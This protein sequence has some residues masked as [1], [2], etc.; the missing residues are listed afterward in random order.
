MR[1]FLKISICIL[2]LGLSGCIPLPKNVDVNVTWQEKPAV[3]ELTASTPIYGLDIL[4]LAKHDANMISQELDSNSVIG[5]LMGTF[6]DIRPNLSILI[7]T[8][9][10]IAVRLH[11]IDGTTNNHGCFGS[12][13]DPN[14]LI[15]KLKIA[16]AF[17]DQYPQVKWYF[18]PVLEHGCTQSSIVQT[19]YNLTR[20]YFPQATPVCSSNGVGVCIAGML[21]ENHGGGSG[22]IVSGDGISTFD[23]DSIAY[24]SAGSVLVLSWHNCCNGRLTSEKPGGPVPPPT[25]R[26]NWCQQ[27]EIRH[28]VRILRAPAPKP[29]VAGCRD[30]LPPD[31]GKPRSENYGIGHGDTRQNKPM[32][33]LSKAGLRQLNI[34][35]L[36]GQTVGCFSEYGPYAGGGERYYE[37]NCSGKN[38]TQLQDLLGSE[39][40]K[41]TSG[42]QCYI[43]NSIRRLGVFR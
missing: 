22:Q 2:L 28:L 12:V 36:G 14:F 20:K 38:P 3:Q 5:V 26:V 18:S 6:G 8:G 35:S 25:Q 24:R 33:I 37:G 17:A 41:L 39:W 9:K 42:N 40:G 16:K 29:V 27:D 15:G 10:V 13:T 43:W 34:Q 7:K 31:I 19:W 21:R 32:V 23:T 1:G 4:G 30:I 11:G